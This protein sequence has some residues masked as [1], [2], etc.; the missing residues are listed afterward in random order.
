MPQSLLN[1]EVFLGELSDMDRLFVRQGRLLAENIM[2]FE[3]GVHFSG[4]LT[5]R[6]LE[7]IGCGAGVRMNL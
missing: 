7:E 3:K 1:G 6:I 2:I 5:E 4:C